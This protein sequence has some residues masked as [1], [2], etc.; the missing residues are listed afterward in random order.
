MN[1]RCSIC[2]A[3][4]EV[5]YWRLC[6]ECFGKQARLERASNDDFRRE[7]AEY[8]PLLVQLCH[9]DR[10]A[11]SPA[12]TRATQWLLALRRRLPALEHVA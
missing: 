12:A 7:V 6:R 10:H 9:P 1:G 3:P 8:L 11:G 5:S 2:R 4:T